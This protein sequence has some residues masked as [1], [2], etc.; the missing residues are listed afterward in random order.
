MSEQAKTPMSDHIQHFWSAI[1]EPHVRI[2]VDMR[3]DHEDGSFHWDSSSFGDDVAKALVGSRA[4][5]PQALAP[6]ELRVRCRLAWNGWTDSEHSRNIIAEHEMRDT[7][8]RDAWDRVIA[9]LDA[10]TRSAP[11]AGC[12]LP[13][14]EVGLAET[15]GYAGADTTHSAAMTDGPTLTEEV[16]SLRKVVAESGGFNNEISDSEPP[17]TDLT[18]LKQQSEKLSVEDQHALAAFIAPN[19]GM[20][21]VN[22]PPHPD[23]PHERSTAITE[24]VAYRHYIT[25]PDGRDS[26]L[27][28]SAPANPWSHWMPEHLDACS[29]VCQPLY[30]TP[31][32][33]APDQ[34]VREALAQAAFELEEAAKI[35]G[36]EYKSTGEIFALA[37][38]RARAALSRPA[39]DAA[40]SD[41]PVSA[42]GMMKANGDLLPCAVAEEDAIYH[43]CA[44]MFDV[45]AEHVRTKLEGAGWHTVRVLISMDPTDPLP[46]ND[47]ETSQPNTD[48][49][50]S[51]PSAA[52][53]VDCG[54]MKHLRNC[55]SLGGFESD[56]TCSLTWRR[57]LATE[58]SI[59]RAWRKRA[60]EAEAL[61]P[62]RMPD[63]ES[64]RTHHRSGS[65]GAA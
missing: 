50:Q 9:A 55:A 14:G 21:L 36:S 49:A 7:P 13:S 8:S 62:V 19:L 31:P 16:A 34:G 39:P 15:P 26:V 41:A 37:A 42:F 58:Q 64:H 30:A 45:S 35:V 4:S 57:A 6:G 54:E 65:L 53:G 32:A 22:E 44:P 25:E 51:A 18:F 1:S 10:A 40:G 20:M 38:N 48:S 61:S 27:L 23:C 52:S 24:P 46:R 43:M 5:A 11:A 33:A 17:L 59:H 47:R 3:R 60:E 56:C 28:S 29:Y 63:K 12:P 2:L